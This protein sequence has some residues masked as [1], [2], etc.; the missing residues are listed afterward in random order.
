MG[1]LREEGQKGRAGGMEGRKEG[2][3]EGGREEPSITPLDSPPLNNTF[4]TQM[5]FDIDSRHI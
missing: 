4:H 5:Q 2:N 3:W 1:G